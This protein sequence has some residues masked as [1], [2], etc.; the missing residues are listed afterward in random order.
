[1]SRALA[2]ARGQNPAPNPRVG[3]VV[4]KEGCIIA[5]A[6]HEA[7]GED[8]AEAAALKLAGEEAAR[9]RS[10]RHPRTLL[11]QRRHE[12]DA[13]LYRSYYRSRNQPCFRR[14]G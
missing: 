2:L 14:L 5:E 9:C 8:H 4:V 1:M 11:S 13:P 7:A 12:E 6:A 10:I 3:A